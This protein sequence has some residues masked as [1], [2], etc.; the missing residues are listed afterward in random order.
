MFLTEAEV[1][2]LT[3]YIKPSKQIQW[4][5]RQ[6]FNFRIA[7]DGHPRVARDHV[8]KVMGAT[9]GNVRAKTEPNFSGVV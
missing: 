5:M 9:S 7:A 4:L 6:G 2:D 3:G 8:L 1:A